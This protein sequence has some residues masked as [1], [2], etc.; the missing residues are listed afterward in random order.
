MVD[1]KSKYFAI[2]D[3][4]ESIW[5]ITGYFRI[6]WSNALYFFGKL[7]KRTGFGP[8]GVGF[9]LMSRKMAFISYNLF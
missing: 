6:P 8:S 7:Y 2:I 1:I 4:G 3:V 5:D 9:I